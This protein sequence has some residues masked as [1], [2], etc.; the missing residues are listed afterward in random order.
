MERSRVDEAKSSLLIKI[1]TPGQLLNSG[2]AYS[3][4]QLLGRSMAERISRDV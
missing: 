1:G 3:R 4:R 2:P